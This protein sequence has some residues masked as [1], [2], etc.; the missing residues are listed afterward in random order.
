MELQDSGSP[1]AFAMHRGR[2]A[3][4]NALSV[5]LL[6]QPKLHSKFLDFR[7]FYFRTVNFEREGG[8][9]AKTTLDKTQERV[10]RFLGFC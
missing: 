1:E 5:E 10:V 9:L 3:R 7:R 8:P 2:G 4:A 6:K